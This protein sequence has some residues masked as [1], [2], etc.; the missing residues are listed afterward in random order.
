MSH[1]GTLSE[2]EV[3]L[4][5]ERTGSYLCQQRVFDYMYYNHTTQMY[6]KWTFALEDCLR[7]KFVSGS[8]IRPERVAKSVKAAIT[9]FTEEPVAVIVDEEQDVVDETDEEDPEYSA[10]SA[11]DEEEDES[12]EEDDDDEEEEK[13]DDDDDDEESESVLETVDPVPVATETKT[14]YALPFVSGEYRLVLRARLMSKAGGEILK[15]KQP[16]IA[17]SFWSDGMWR[18]HENCTLQ[19]LAD[20]YNITEEQSF[21]DEEDSEWQSPVEAVSDETRMFLMHQHS[22]VSIPPLISVSG[23]TNA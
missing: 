18:I 5:L 9:T 1:F 10:E 4:E 7:E 22:Y 13:Q 8:D 16:L 20:V 3:L 15:G 2:T 23:S 14:E 17:F 6:E 12:E 11:S 21:F 19:Q